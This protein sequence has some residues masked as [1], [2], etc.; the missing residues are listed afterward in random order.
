MDK[1]TQI[2]HYTKVGNILFVIFC[3]VAGSIAPNG[4]ALALPNT[5]DKLFRKQNSR[6]RRLASRETA[7]LQMFNRV[8][9]ARLLPGPPA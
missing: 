4:A 3:T 9:N 5:R 1:R 7:K 8:S 6:L 2:F